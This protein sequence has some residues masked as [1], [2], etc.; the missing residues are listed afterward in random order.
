[1]LEIFDSSYLGAHVR[2][3]AIHP[4]GLLALE[5]PAGILSHPNQRDDLSR[6]LIR[7]PYDE[8]NEWFL[9]PDGCRVHLLHRLDA[10]TSGVLLVTTQPEIANQ[11]R[12]SFSAHL[13]E[14]T[15]VALSFG[16][17]RRRQEI[18]EDRLQLRKEGR[19][20]RSTSG[21]NEGSSAICEMRQIHLFSGQ[22]PMTLLELKPRTG[23]THQLRVQCQVRRLPIVGDATYG[24]FAKN[25]QFAK[26]TCHDRLFLHAES[27][28]V[29]FN[30]KGREERFHV[31]CPLPAEFL[32]PL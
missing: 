14:K 2:P 27:V 23:R 6:S 18:W 9:L 26:Q 20:L 32:K 4:S 15:Y 10:A 7:A 1:M 24:D 28:G 25:R 30:W 21:S 16:V 22:P 11:L 3:I 8:T 31:G 13:V 12:R 5:K 17:P 29:Q 19:R